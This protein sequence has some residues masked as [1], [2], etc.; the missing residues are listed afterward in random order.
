MPPS[1]YASPPAF[2]VPDA[3]PACARWRTLE[4]LADEGAVTPVIRAAAVRIRAQARALAPGGDPAWL[5]AALA[6]AETQ[7]LPY[8]APPDGQQWFQPVTQTEAT[9]GD[10]GN[11]AA[12]LVARL[13]AL[14]LTA[15]V[16]WITQTGQR[17]NH[18]TVAVWL[19]GE[20]RWAEPSIKGAALGESPYDAVRRVG[21]H[22]VLGAARAA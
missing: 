4:D 22:H 13:R 3:V 10:C 20:W 9:G 1:P 2:R 12:N 8:V 14:G 6:L 5:E 19:G 21:Q 18:V 7:A 11:L 15:Q 16:I 17:V